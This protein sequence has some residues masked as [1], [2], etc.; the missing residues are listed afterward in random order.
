MGAVMLRSVPRAAVVFALMS[1]MFAAYGSCAAAGLSLIYEFPPTADGTARSGGAP[2]A[3]V[4]EDVLGALYGTTVDGGNYDTNGYGGGVVYKLTPPAKGKTAWT[5]S[6]LHA[7]TGGADGIFPGSG[8]LIV[9]AGDIYGTTN[10]NAS[11]GLC[12]AKQNISCD[13]IFKLAHPAAGK[14]NYT[15]SLLYRFAAPTKGFE[16]VG[17]LIMNKAGALIGA[18]KAGGNTN[19]QSSFT[20]EQGTK[21]C[22]AIYQLEPPA[23]GKTAWTYSVLHLFT[24]GADGGLPAAS[25]LADPSGSGVLYG[26]ASTGGSQNCSLGAA[27]CGVVFKLTPPAG[28]ATKWTETVLYSFTGQTDG[29]GPLAALVIDRAGNLYGTTSAAGDACQLF[30][31]CG[32]AFELIKEKSGYRFKA[33]HGFAGG[34]DGSIP[35]AALTLGKNG[36]LYG[37]TSRYGNANVECGSAIGCGT[38]YKLNPPTRDIPVWTETVLYRFNSGPDGGASSASLRLNAASGLLYGT[39]SQGGNKKCLLASFTVGCGVVF[40]LHE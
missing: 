34:T 28:K 25:L 36:V 32:T 6:V 22:G 11:I 19:C 16:P 33:L 37:T 1:G 29:A 15:Y 31:G 26:T 38:I 40:S 4:T 17:G 21:G 20:N 13:T 5:E 24:G 12:G 27:N 35:L 8:N 7:F 14:T 30:T 18:A 9:S 10:G 2:S 39:A 3:G 23:K